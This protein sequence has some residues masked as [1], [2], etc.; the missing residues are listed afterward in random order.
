[1][2]GLSVD[3]ER[4]IAYRIAA[5]GLDRRAGAEGPGAAGPGVLDLAVLDLGV[6]DTPYGTAAMALTARTDH[7]GDAG[8]ALSLVWAARGAPHLH[9]DAD[10][11][12]LARALWP[13]SDADATARIDSAQIK[14]GAALGI[15]AFEAAAR[16]MREVVREPMAKGEVSAAV[17]ARVP[18]SLTYDCRGCRARHLSTALFAQ[19]GLAAGVTVRPEGRRTVLAPIPGWPGVPERAE[20]TDAYMAAYLRLLGPATPAEVAGFLGTRRAEA[21]RVWPEGTVEVSVAGRACHLPADRVDDLLGAPRP[22]AVRLLPASDPYLQARD[23]D[24]IVPD[25]ARRRELWRPLGNPG[26]LLVDGEILGV[27]RAKK[28]GRRLDVTVT[29]FEPLD[30]RVRAAAGAEAAR[31]AETRGAAEARLDVT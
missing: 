12:R 8:D 30:A 6:Q 21:R 17:S 18:E 26:A 19:V 7:A 23:R 1:M 25:A 9:R 29:A 3:R 11:V 2:A 16:A 28:A 15:A 22:E 27:W 13:L 14:E 20:G 5:Q 10:L 4:V 31:L 24:L